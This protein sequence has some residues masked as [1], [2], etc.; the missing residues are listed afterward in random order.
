VQPNYTGTFEVHITVCAT[1]IAAREK[2]C[3]LCQTLRVKSVLIELPQGIVPKQLM[4]ASHHRGTLQSVKQQAYSLARKFD[5]AGFEIARVK[6]E[7][8]VHN[9]DVPTSDAQAQLLPTTNY[10]EFH[11]KVTLAPEDIEM[12]AQLCQEYN[13][14]LSVNAF[15]HQPHG[16]QQRFITMRA[17][18]VGLNS[19]FMSFNALLTV[20]KAKGLKLSQPQQEYTVFDSNINIDSGWFTGESNG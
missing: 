5:L 8:M 11:V 19:A 7:A 2:F 14:H 16:I 12:L 13:A 10:F 18:S 4:T 17:Y 3:C 9:Q 20:L 15:K 6:I 1:D